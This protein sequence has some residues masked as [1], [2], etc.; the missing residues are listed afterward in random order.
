MEKKST[1][2]YVKKEFI[3]LISSFMYYH[4]N[5]IEC[6]EELAQF[7]C[8]LNYKQFLKIS[9]YLY[10]D[11][12]QSTSVFKQIGSTFIILSYNPET[13]LEELKDLEIIRF[14]LDKSSSL[15][16]EALNEYVDIHSDEKEKCKLYKDYIQS[17][18]KKIKKKK[19]VKKKKL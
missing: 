12:K 16:T 1:I 7:I 15:D 5:Q 2:K 19:I 6:Q 13:V 14:I 10:D 18:K 17:E 8:K 3:S 11:E 9:K 4:K